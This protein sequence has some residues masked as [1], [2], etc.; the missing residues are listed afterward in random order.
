MLHFQRLHFFHLL[1]KQVVLHRQ[2]VLDD[3]EATNSNVH[4]SKRTKSVSTPARWSV[5]FPVVKKYKTKNTD[6]LSRGIVIRKHLKNEQLTCRPAMWWPIN[7]IF[8]KVDPHLRHFLNDFWMSVTF[9]VVLQLQTCFYVH[10]E[11]SGRVH[12]VHQSDAPR[13]W[14]VSSSRTSNR[15]SI[16]IGYFWNARVHCKV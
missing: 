11:S 9:R 2:V 1:C 16:C 5:P 6:W 4:Q 7:E 10:V 13:L 14:Q 12:F 8:W 15:C 3:E